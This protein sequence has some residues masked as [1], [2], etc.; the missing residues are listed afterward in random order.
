MNKKLE[1]KYNEFL[2][3][4]KRF[5]DRLE[6]NTLE[7]NQFKSSPT[8]WSPLEVLEHIQ[9]SE[10]GILKFFQKYNPA[11]SKHKPKGKDKV[12][13]F[14]LSKLYRSSY[15]VKVPVKGL[16]PTG[17]KSLE[18]LKKESEITKEK[19][20]QYLE[21]LPDE[22]INY[23]VFKHPV[24]GGMTMESVVAFWTNHVLHHLHQLDRIEKEKGFHQEI[25]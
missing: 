3:M 8:E 23:S 21:N 15:K 4:K 10:N 20:K 24:S 9:I 19:L 14:L 18:E 5:M 1:I 12:I 11:E 6:K 22:K 17:K 7:Q 13:N 2:S 25:N 16:D